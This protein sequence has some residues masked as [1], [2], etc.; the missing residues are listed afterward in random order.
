MGAARTSSIS[1]LVYSS[2]VSITSCV[3]TAPS[4]RKIDECWGPPLHGNH[5][6]GL[7][8]SD[9]GDPLDRLQDGVR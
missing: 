9:P 3:N 5:D 2:Q 1:F 8:A 4:S 7:G 6:V